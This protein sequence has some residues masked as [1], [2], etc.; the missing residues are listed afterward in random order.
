MVWGGDTVTGGND[1]EETAGRSI[2][3]AA[4]IAA[5][6]RWIEQMAI[7]IA[8]NNDSTLDDSSAILQQFRSMAANSRFAW[9]TT[10]GTKLA[11]G[12]FD[13]ATACLLIA[14]MH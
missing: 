14:L 1:S 10:I 9:L 11:D 12:D 6:K 8:L 13:D 5:G 3:G 4:N 2:A 7:W